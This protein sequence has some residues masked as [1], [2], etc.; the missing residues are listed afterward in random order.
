[1]TNPDSALPRRSFVASAGLSLAGARAVRGDGARPLYLL[2]YDHGGLVLWG[3][4]HWTGVG[5]HAAS[6]FRSSRWT[7]KQ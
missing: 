7:Q 2:T 6:A 5:R 1:M 4:Y 3:I